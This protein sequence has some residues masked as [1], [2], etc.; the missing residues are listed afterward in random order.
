MLNR[1]MDMKEILRLRGHKFNMLQAARL[2]DESV[3][4]NL[5][6]QLGL[7]W[8]IIRKSHNYTEIRAW[9]TAS[10]TES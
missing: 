8:N 6:Q 1:P 4:S 7:L 9:W 2:V 3:D 10:N 5:S